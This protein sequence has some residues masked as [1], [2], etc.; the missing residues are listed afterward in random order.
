MISRVAKQN[1]FDSMVKEHME[2][3]E[4]DYEAAAKDVKIQMEIQKYNTSFL[5][6]N[7][8][9]KL[10]FEEK[11]TNLNNLFKSHEIPVDF[12][13]IDKIFDS[14]NDEKKPLDQKELQFKNCQYY[15]EKINKKVIKEFM[16]CMDT[17]KLFCNKYLNYRVYG[18]DLKVH[19]LMILGLTVREIQ[20][21]CL[22]GL[23]CIC[24]SNSD[25]MTHQIAKY[26]LKVINAECARDDVELYNSLGFVDDELN[27]SANTYQEF[28]DNKRR[29]D[30][31]VFNYLPMAHGGIYTA[32]FIEAC[33]CVVNFCD[34]NETNR[35]IFKELNVLSIIVAFF[36][37]INTQC[38]K[39]LSTTKGDLEIESKSSENVLENEYQFYNFKKLHPNDKQL[40]IVA[41]CRLGFIFLVDDDIRTNFGSAH[42]NAKFLSNHLNLQCI[43]NIFKSNYRIL[44][45]MDGHESASRVTF[46]IGFVFIYQFNDTNDQHH[47]N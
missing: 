25:F 10:N 19:H 20:L 24:R 8:V 1:E 12:S 26:L 27:V 33:E 5:I 7:R 39:R 21:D 42:D 2:F 37:T 47:M 23:R 14:A 6:L 46:C 41:L 45:C 31:K 40:C 18:I 17:I 22:T 13:I 43:L 34:N 15:F 30:V 9:N 16:D 36:D 35:M 3:L 29:F 38:F 4:I 28:V 32:Y 44:Y 11:I